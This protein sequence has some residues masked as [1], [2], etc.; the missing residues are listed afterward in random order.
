MINVQRFYLAKWGRSCL[1]RTPPE[2]NVEPESMCYGV[3]LVVSVEGCTG[4]VSIDM[5]MR[6]IRMV[7]SK[8]QLLRRSSLGTE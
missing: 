6:V 7:G 8:R 4:V 1:P 2:L 5:D 3:M